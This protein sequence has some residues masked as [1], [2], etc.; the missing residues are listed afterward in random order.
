MLRRIKLYVVLTAEM[1]VT[2]ASLVP[3]RLDARPKSGK[4]HHHTMTLS[5]NPLISQGRGGVSKDFV[6]VP[7]LFELKCG[8]PGKISCRCGALY[9]C[10]C[11]GKPQGT[12]KM[13]L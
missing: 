5:W 12:K 1:V 13:L 9:P 3:G 6:E 4:W 11:S 2:S 7:E 10:N 8:A